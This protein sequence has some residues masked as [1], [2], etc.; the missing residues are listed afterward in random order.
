MMEGEE[1]KA[2][3]REIGGCIKALCGMLD[4]LECDVDVENYPRVMYGAEREAEPEPDQQQEEGHSQGLEQAPDREEQRAR[5]METQ[6]HGT[7]GARHRPGGESNHERGLIQVHAGHEA[8]KSARE[9]GLAE[10]RRTKST[11]NEGET[12]D[13]QCPETPRR[14]RTRPYAP[15]FGGWDMIDSLTVQ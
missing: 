1:W 15:E 14:R 10:R 3:A 5:E 4:A 7:K 11:T 9:K 13:M 12:D 8:N 6:H 2:A